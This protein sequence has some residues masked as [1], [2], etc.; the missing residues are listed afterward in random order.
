M[1]SRSISS[2][3]F[4]RT[5]SRAATDRG[6]SLIEVLIATA[7]GAILFSITAIITFDDYRRGNFHQEVQS[8]VMLLQT[9]RSSAINNIGATAHGIAFNTREHGNAYVLFSGPSFV[10]GDMI[11]VVEPRVDLQIA[12]G[13]YREVLFEQLSG[14][15]P[16]DL[17]LSVVEIHGVGKTDITLNREGRIDW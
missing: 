2:H 11:S 6:F 14:D 10:D 3:K 5:K 4:G 16:D 13:V 12:D 9:A 8:I 17:I 7:I 15:T 1:A